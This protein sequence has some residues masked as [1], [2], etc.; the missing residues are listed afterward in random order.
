[1]DD[2][3]N[4]SPF[5]EELK[6]A[7]TQREVALRVLAEFVADH[8]D[9]AYTTLRKYGYAPKNTSRESIITAISK[10]TD[11]KKFITELLGNTQAWHNAGGGMDPLTA[12]FNMAAELIGG[13]FS[14]GQGKQQINLEKE[15][16]RGVM[17][18]FLANRDAS[19]SAA[20]VA[21]I[22]AV[23]QKRIAEENRRI[24]AQ[25]NKLI[26]QIAGGVGFIIVLMGV[27]Y[28]ATRPTQTQTAIK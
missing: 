5:R 7:L 13:A 22:N 9:R 2:Q 18:N 1:M 25:D 20:D 15:K 21:A 19:R 10:H 4:I 23:A 8:A 3:I 16:N 14:I 11:D 26:L 24:A 28:F 17:M 12:G 6:P 27:V